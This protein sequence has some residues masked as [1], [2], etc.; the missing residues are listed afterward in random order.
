MTHPDQVQGGGKQIR[1]ILLSCDYKINHCPGQW[2]VIVTPLWV[3][4]YIRGLRGLRLLDSYHT[5]QA[6]ITLL[7]AFSIKGKK[8]AFFTLNDLQSGARWAKGLGEIITRSAMARSHL[9][10][11]APSREGSAVR[12]VWDWRCCFLHLLLSV[13][14]WLLALGKKRKNKS[15]LNLFVGHFSISERKNQSAEKTLLSSDT[16]LSLR[17]NTGPCNSDC[18]RQ[19][20]MRI[21]A[22]P[23][24]LLKR[25]NQGWWNGF[26]SG[27]YSNLAACELLC[28]ASQPGLG[29]SHPA[30][31]LEAETPLG[32][33]SIPK[34]FSLLPCSTRP[35]R[36]LS[37]EANHC[38]ALVLSR[39][40]PPHLLNQ[41]TMNLG[42]SWPGPTQVLAPPHTYVAMQ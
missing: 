18:H 9:F 12:K 21:S 28:P 14:S 4:Q 17:K 15:V 41:H 30:A 37:H 19:M 24:A 8:I 6:P 35:S 32:Q 42:T 5:F 16:A 1:E 26:A 10:L 38:Q 3:L 7:A 27:S 40:R 39:T 33:L 13:M 36:M 34:W 11:L 20:A 29:P 31:L 2:V 22:E 25:G 23:F